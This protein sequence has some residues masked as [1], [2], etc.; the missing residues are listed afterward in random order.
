[1]LVKK[2]QGRAE[3][4]G[5]R[6]GGR[7]REAGLSINFFPLT[8]GSLFERGGGLNRGFTVIS[9]IESCRNTKQAAAGAS[10]L[11]RSIVN[12]SDGSSCLLGKELKMVYCDDF[13][14]VSSQCKVKCTVLV[15][16]WKR[17]V[18]KNH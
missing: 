4:V 16:R 18:Q 14:C 10:Y 1:M 2:N 7:K 9:V 6:V 17:K 15:H 8:R 3:G 11:T 13:C 5:G 12:L